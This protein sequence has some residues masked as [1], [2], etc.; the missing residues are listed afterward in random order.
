MLIPV[1]AEFSQ[2]A[3][4][5]DIY[6]ISN[7]VHADIA[8]PIRSEAADWS[9]KLSVADFGPYGSDANYMSFGWGDQAIFI[10]M[11]TWDDLTFTIGAGALLGLNGTAMHLQPLTIPA[12]P[13]ALPE[14]IRRIRISP[15]QLKALMD[16]MESGFIRE[17]GERKFIKIAGAV[18]TESDA[19]YRASGRYSPF[20]TCNEWARRGLAEAGIRMPVWSPFVP[21][22]FYQLDRIGN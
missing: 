16:Y 10:D 12:V 15:A 21:G 4:G 5:V 19:F 1:N 9:E 22:I 13:E 8:V 17:G 18:Y 2:P 6:I 7:G 14:H 20:F 11:P 3:D